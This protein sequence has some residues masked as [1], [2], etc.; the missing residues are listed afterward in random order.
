[1]NRAIVRSNIGTETV[2][3][4]ERI[5]TTEEELV[6]ASEGLPHMFVYLLERRYLNDLDEG[7]WLIEA[8]KNDGAYPLL[9]EV[10]AL[11]KQRHMEEWSTAMPHVLSA[12]HDP[13]NGLLMSVFH[14]G[15]RPHIYLGGRRVMG[16]G[17]RNSADFLQAQEGAFRAYFSGLTLEEEPRMLTRQELPELSDF[18]LAAPSLASVTGIPAR[19]KSV[20]GLPFELQSIDQL[21]K[22]AGGG[23]YALV[24]AAEPIRPE[25]IDATLDVCRRLIGFVHGF[26]AVTKSYATSR[27]ES[28]DEQTTIAP[29]GNHA[30]HIQMVLG[31]LH[32]AMGF[33]GRTAFGVVDPLQLFGGMTTFAHAFD[34]L[35]GRDNEVTQMRTT[36]TQGIN[37]QMSAT[38]LDASAEACERLL[39][40]YV[41]RLESAHSM[42]WWNTAIYLAAENESVLANAAGALRS[43]CTGE[44]TALDPIRVH[45]LPEYLLREAITKGQVLGFKPGTGSQGH[46]FGESFDCLST[47][48]TSEELAVI[49]NLPRTEMPGIPMREMTEFHLSTGTIGDEPQTKQSIEIGELTDSMGRGLSSVRITENMLNRHVM[50]TGIPGAGKT[51]TCWHLL[52]QTWIELR[53]PFLVIEPA[54]AEY[55]RLT[56]L[57]EFKDSLRVYSVGGAGMPLRLNPFDWVP[58]VPLLRHINLLK[59]I[60]ISSLFPPGQ[61]SPLPFLVE[62]ALLEVY[63]DRGWDLHTSFNPYLGDGSLRVRSA[64]L[65]RL[66]DFVK[67]LQEVVDQRGY[68][69]V[70]RDRLQ[71]YLTTRLRSVTTGIKGLT[72]NSRRSTPFKRLFESPVVIE[73]KEIGDED[74]KAFLMALI[75]GLL[76]EYAEVRVTHLAEHDRERLQ[77]LTL[78]EEAHRLLKPGSGA[79]KLSTDPAQKAVTMFTD[80]LAEMRAYGEGF[81]IVDQIPTKLASETL[82]NTNLK[83]VHRLAAADDRRVVGDCMNLDEQQMRSL[84]NLRP[85]MAVLHFEDVGEPILCRVPN[86]KERKPEAAASKLTGVGNKAGPDRGDGIFLYRHAGCEYCSSPCNYFHEVEA[87]AESFSQMAHGVPAGSAGGK[88]GSEG[89]STKRTQG[90]VHALGIAFMPVVGSIVRGDAEQAASEFINWCR[91]A[92]RKIR[93][94]RDAE[95]QDAVPILYCA[96]AQAVHFQLGELLESRG[97]AVRERRIILPADLVGRER[98]AGALS[99]LISVWLT[100]TDRKLTPAEVFQWTRDELMSAIFAAPPGEMS[101]NV[102]CVKCPTRC[103]MLPFVGGTP[104]EVAHKIGSKV[105]TMQT[106]QARGAYIFEILINSRKS[107]AGDIANVVAKIDKE[108][109]AWDYCVS[110]N[111]SYL[112]E[113][114]LSGLEATQREAVLKILEHRSDEI[115]ESGA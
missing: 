29:G 30:P 38:F 13:G 3:T 112:L 63:T 56:E 55:F 50:V 66:D 23:R 100:G 110:A 36:Q 95:G 88:A 39:R 85:G 34:S 65:P 15:S 7:H 12:C 53:V 47:C 92:K 9:R 68:D 106:P 87:A 98:A 14:D 51:N 10:R 21:L 49:V 72:L 48:L 91:L 45:V 67:K 64:L 79:N 101:D 2:G 81:V 104:R 17:G 46:P 62:D 57:P 90:L 27:Q 105:S 26:A 76:Y 113:E 75:F 94:A 84:N 97:A 37:N 80:M 1:M 41:R 93:S 108:Y 24:I 58:G 60:L 44:A 8:R 61:D 89:R 82:K 86:M 99:R 83:I 4:G 52:R 102:P 11:G 18:L 40:E 32:S 107:L 6:R 77:H 103:L 111:L 78:I 114:N 19:R 35:R 109:A 73:L 70:V 28:K 59:T 25:V 16:Q 96:A 31:V 22:A 115:S 5:F 20:A 71:A 54:K 33:M 74:E 42:G 43:M 69:N